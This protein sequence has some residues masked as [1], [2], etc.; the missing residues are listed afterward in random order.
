MISKVFRGLTIEVW[1]YIYTCAGYD[2]TLE[3]YKYL[4][5]RYV[6]LKSFAYIY[7]YLLQFQFNLALPNIEN[8]SDRLHQYNKDY[9]TLF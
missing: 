3:T 6:Y 5:N 7:I 4:V 9:I 1:L 2:H 8:M